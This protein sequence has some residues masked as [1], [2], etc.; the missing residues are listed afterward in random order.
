M[1]PLPPPQLLL[2]RY[3]L[4]LTLILLSSGVSAQFEREVAHNYGEIET[5][6]STAVSGALRS[7]SSSTSALFANPA[8]MALTQVYHV[9]GFAQIFPEAGKQLFGAAVVDSL[10]SSTGLA[11]G[12][13]AAWSQQDPGNLGRQWTDLR[14]GLALPIPEVL[15]V[16]AS[17]RY[18]ALKQDGV[19]PLGAS[20]A[21]GGLPNQA[22][23]ETVTLDAGVTLRPIPELVIALVGQNLTSPDAT[24]FPLMGG[25]SAGYLTGDV[26]VGADVVLET[27]LVSKPRVRAQV[28]GEVLLAERVPVRAGYRYDQALDSH[29]VSLGVGYT[30]PKFSIDLGARR[31]LVGPEY[32]SVTLGFSV[33]MEALSL[34]PTGNMD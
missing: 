25:L 21:S 6:R 11:G 2:A 10:L 8:N 18:V 4:P 17:G 1:K 19:G 12:L 23:L 14:F 13:S 22:I 34:G 28:G 16:G 26:S 7:T 15:Y 27:E 24:L 20:L 33:H 29:A 5:P 30:D 9:G 32:T 3:A 31:S